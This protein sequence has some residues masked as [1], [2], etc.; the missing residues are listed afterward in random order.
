MKILLFG[1]D[2]LAKHIIKKSDEFNVDIVHIASDKIDYYKQENI[3][4]IITDYNY[5]IIVYSDLLDAN[6]IKFIGFYNKMNKSKPFI[7][8]S[9][10]RVF[11]DTETYLT[12]KTTPMPKCNIKKLLLKIQQDFLKQNN[13]NHVLIRTSCVFYDDKNYKEAFSKYSPDS[14]LSPAYLPDY[15]TFILKT[16]IALHQ[17]NET[18]LQ[19]IKLNDNILHYSDAYNDFISADDIQKK[20]GVSPAKDAIYICEIIKGISY[21]YFWNNLDRII[22]QE[23]RDNIPEKVEYQNNIKIS[24]STF[25]DSDGVY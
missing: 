7:L 22:L 16:A 23:E 2:N 25:F 6:A 18:V 12:P 21:T 17:K 24:Y 15:A 1:D 20:I 13:S 5:D 11:D 14:F 9:S 19:A 4:N 10:V 8:C 3:V